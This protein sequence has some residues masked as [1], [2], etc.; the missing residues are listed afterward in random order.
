MKI[1]TYI[2]S[3]LNFLSFSLCAGDRSKRNVYDSVIN[4]VL[5]AKC[6]SCHGQDKDKGKLRMHT[7]SELIKGGRGAGD[8]IIVQGKVDESEL[9]FR[10][11]LPKDDEEAMPPMENETHYNPVTTEE[12]SVLQSWIKLG[13]SFD[14][15]INDLDDAGRIAAEHVLKNL[16]EKKESL[17]AM[18][19]PKL[20]EV[21]PANEDKIEELKSKGVLIMPIAQNTNAL[22]INAS[23]LGES[24]DD[25]SV[26]MLLPLAP[27]LIW[28]NLA[29]TSVTDSGMEL[30][31]S[32]TLLERLHAENTN[33]S[34]KS[35]IHLSKLTNLKY[36]NMYGTKITDASISNLQQLQRLE[37][38]FLWQTKVTKIGAETLRKGFIDPNLYSRLSKQKRML[39]IE[40]EKFTE[41]FTREITEIENTVSSASRSTSDVNPINEKC[42]VTNKPADKAIT[43]NFEGRKVS[44]CCE[45]CKSKFSNDRASFKSKL[46]NFKASTNFEIVS[47]SLI[48]KQREMD[49]EL[50]AIGA[51]LRSVSQ[52]LNSFGPEINLGWTLAISK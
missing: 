1:L 47:S 24:F 34:D 38:I 21:P 4:P 50:E 18:L 29:R 32:L 16:P 36:L 28:L 41:K 12:L 42:P 13:A 10:I 33:L 2:L 14:M 25:E 22:Y 7:K 43:T 31:S 3:L 46:G 27:Q 44:F 5:Q 8:A 39:E 17:T 9:I 49:K 19:I 35:S 23:Y 51:K 15:V 30:I 6:V 11:T 45:K 52:E 48:S 20:P 37:K 40:K 26:K